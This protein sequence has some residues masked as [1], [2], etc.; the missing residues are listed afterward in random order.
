M[1]HLESDLQKSCVRWFSHQYAQYRELL[2]AIPNGGYRNNIEAVRFKMEGV[3]AGVSDLCLAV[4]K[5]DFGA[6]Y[7]EMKSNQG[8]VS[9]LQKEWQEKAENAGNKC[10]VCRSLD[11]FMCIVNEYMSLQ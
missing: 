11:E 3:R 7:I 8:R 4:K 10:V 5:G 1:R 6:L 9:K 2:Y